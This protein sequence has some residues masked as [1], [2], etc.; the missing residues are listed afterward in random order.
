LQ[1]DKGR[2][3][4]FARKSTRKIFLIFFLAK[5]KALPLLAMEKKSTTLGRP[6]KDPERIK[7]AYSLSLTKAEVGRLDELAQEAKLGRSEYV[8]EK[9][10]LDKRVI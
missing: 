9:L 3:F 10:G 8:I 7:H 6:T 4:F 5:K 1:R 2:A